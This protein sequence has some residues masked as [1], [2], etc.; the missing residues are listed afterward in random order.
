MDSHA[1]TAHL[2]ML[3]QKI[4]LHADHNSALTRIQLSEL[5]KNAMHANHATLA[6]LLMLCKD[7]VSDKNLLAL[8][9]KSMVVMDT[10]ALNVQIT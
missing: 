5:L 4:E 2:D 8:V 3:L 6:I 1:L 7:N 9:P 10:N